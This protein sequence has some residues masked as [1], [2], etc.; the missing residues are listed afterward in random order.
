MVKNRTGT[1]C[2]V[3]DCAQR[4]RE[5]NVITI[6]PTNMIQAWCLQH[7]LSPSDDFTKRKKEWINLLIYPAS[8]NHHRVPI[9]KYRVRTIINICHQG[10]N[11]A[12]AQTIECLSMR[13]GLSPGDGLSQCADSAKNSVVRRI[14]CCESLSLGFSFNSIAERAVDVKPVDRRPLDPSV[15]ELC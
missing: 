8:S 14:W 2:G 5:Y 4:C 15:L 12:P 13:A 3:L 9:F 1:D 7:P 11:R 6:F 10:A